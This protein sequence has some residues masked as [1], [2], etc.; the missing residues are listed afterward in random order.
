MLDLID[1]IE[2]ETEKLEEPGLTDDLKA[3]R[4]AI[5]EEDD[6]AK[7]RVETFENAQAEWA[8]GRDALQERAS[9]LLPTG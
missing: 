9:R 4:T 3:A 5:A 7:D 6:L 8:A 2:G 1:A